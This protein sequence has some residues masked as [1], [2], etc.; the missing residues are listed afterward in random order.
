M[1]RKILDC[2]ANGVP[3]FLLLALQPAFAGDGEWTPLNPVPGGAVSNFIAD[4]DHMFFISGPTV[5]E[6]TDAGLA[7]S[8]FATFESDA[9]A[10]ALDPSDPQ[11]F[12]AST[13]AGILQSVDGGQNW[14][15]IGEQFAYWEEDDVMGNVEHGPRVIELVTSSDG[16]H[17]YARL[18]DEDG[19]SPD[20]V[21]VRTDGGEWNPVSQDWDHLHIVRVDPTVPSR[22]YAV[23]QEYEPGIM[24]SDDAGASWT[25]VSWAEAAPCG[26][27]PSKARDLKIDPAN[28]ERLFVIGTAFCD[29]VLRSENGGQDWE[30]LDIDF[31]ETDL[32]GIGF[33]WEMSIA[34]DPSN[35]RTVYAIQ[36]HTQ[37]GMLVHRSMDGGDSWTLLPDASRNTWSTDR[38]DRLKDRPAILAVSASEPQ[39]QV[40]A[41]TRGLWRTTD[42]GNSWAPHAQSFN[43]TGMLGFDRLQGTAEGMLALMPAGLLR[44]DDG[45][46]SWRFLPSEGYPSIEE[47]H[48]FAANPMNHDE[49]WLTADGDLLKTTDGGRTWANQDVPDPPNV[50]P[51]YY[52]VIGVNSNDPR[53][54]IVADYSARTVHVTTTAGSTW[55]THDNMGTFM[56]EIAFSPSD[57]TVYLARRYGGLLRS[58]NGGVSW[59]NK[60]FDDQL[61]TYSVAVHPENSDVVYVVRNP[62]VLKSVNGGE[63]WTVVMGG[64]TVS[65]GKVAVDPRD[66]RNVLVATTSHVYASKD[67]GETWAEMPFPSTGAGGTRSILFDPVVDERYFIELETV[68]NSFLG[69]SQVYVFD[70]PLPDPPEPPPVSGNDPG[71]SDPDIS[72]R[73][74]GSGGGATSWLLLLIALLGV[75]RLDAGGMRR[76]Q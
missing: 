23:V 17:V 54:V 64:K 67:A 14:E 55:T 51:I 20:G 68:A 22:I 62:G 29:F 75:G 36:Y 59:S 34:F 41:G 27:E 70:G 13:D 69:T 5:Y 44:S 58:R 33:T 53:N 45:G 4:G 32:D 35:T 47:A 8:E 25:N 6:S 16:R 73:G 76:R 11:R 63:D 30:L 15:N 42:G 18:Y 61:E 43:H 24:R 37:L 52:T 1:I 31:P 71:D 46:D 38:P 7:W 12:Y 26:E 10:F 49:V 9:H 21:V 2:M 66:G 39:T 60:S 40:I 3:V 65:G 74:G 72:P 56:S 19:A 48:A 28:S 50:S 57:G